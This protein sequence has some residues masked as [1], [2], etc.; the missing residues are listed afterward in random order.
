MDDKELV[1]KSRGSFDYEKRKTGYGKSGEF[2]RN[3]YLVYMHAYLKDNFR[4]SLTNKKLYIEA[5]FNSIN[6]INYEVWLLRTFM[7]EL[8]TTFT[9]GMLL[10]PKE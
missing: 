7:G 3:A 5:T 2:I 6:D 10:V 8:A 9:F 1:K 4:L